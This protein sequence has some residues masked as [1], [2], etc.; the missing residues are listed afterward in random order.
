MRDSVIERVRPSS[1]LP[2]EVLDQPYKF[3]AQETVSHICLLPR[4]PISADTS[5]ECYWHD[6]NCVPQTVHLPS[7]RG[8]W[9]RGSVL[10]AC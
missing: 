8:R 5:C 10:P 4:L 6:K 9:Q 1:P 3:A 2:E 7:F